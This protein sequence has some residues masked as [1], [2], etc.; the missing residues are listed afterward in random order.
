MTVSFDVDDHPALV[1][2]QGE[3]SEQDIVRRIA[4]G[5]H[6]AFASMMRA[7]NR[8]LFRLARAVLRNDE[9]TEEALQVAYLAAYRAI[10]QFRGESSLSTWLSRLVLNECFGRVR[11]AK[12]RSDA[13]PIVDGDGRAD[14]V[15]MI[16][17][18]GGTPEQ[19]AS[20]AELRS[21]LERRIDELPDAFRVV[22]VLRS[23][24]EMSVEETA[25]CLDLPE[26]TVRSRHHRARRMLRG[27][28]VRDLDVAE[29]DAFDFCGARCDRLVASVLALVRDGGST[30]D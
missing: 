1:G 14:E 20:R 18:I 2:E 10:G 5:D 19:A 11:R 26:A 24:E 3:H 12:R 6:A 17:D 23:V 25:Q 21:L 27:A 4:A 7:H 28:L 9:E 29:R 22:F 30:G 8:R 16:D 15:D 13:M